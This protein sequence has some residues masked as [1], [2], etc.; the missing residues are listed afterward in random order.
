MVEELNRQLTELLRARTLTREEER[1]RLLN[2]AKDASKADLESWQQYFQSRLQ[3]LDVRYDE[4][5]L[6]LDGP[7]DVQDPVLR[8]RVALLRGFVLGKQ[9]HPEEEIAA[10]EVVLR[11]GLE[12][13]DTAVQSLACAA[14]LYKGEVLLKTGNTKDAAA[15]FKAVVDQQPG[16]AFVGAE[17]VSDAKYR[18]ALIYSDNGDHSL[19]LATLQDLEE[20]LG[21]HE[22]LTE[23]L[24]A[25]LAA[26]VNHLPARKG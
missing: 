23:E 17:I 9:D 13:Q 26:H 20:Y 12:S 10:Y 15:L 19:A 18:L 24:A 25:A 16:G 1:Q 7:A 6:I 14:R 5:L 4:A 21:E 11:E 22:D 3:V 2:L 8:C